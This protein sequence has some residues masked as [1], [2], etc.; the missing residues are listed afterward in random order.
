MGCL[1]C[2]GPEFNMDDDINDNNRFH[3]FIPKHI[4]TKDS[5]PMMEPKVISVKSIL[6]SSKVRRI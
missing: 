6:E 2:E 4:L 1:V 3:N 5:Y